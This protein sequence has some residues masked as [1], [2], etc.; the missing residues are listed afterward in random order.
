MTKGTER[1]WCK[2][3]GA[4]ISGSSASP[5]EMLVDQAA[6]NLGVTEVDLEL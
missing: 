3:N 2:Q 6:Q 1:L 5:H 4:L